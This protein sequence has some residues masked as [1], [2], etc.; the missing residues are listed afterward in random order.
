MNTDI[1]FR[2][3]SITDAN[4]MSELNS[5]N[6]PQNYP[7]YYWIYQLLFSNNSFLAFKDNLLIGYVFSF[8]LST[9]QQQTMQTAT[10]CSLVVDPDYRKLGIASK[11]L[12]LTKNSYTIPIKLILHVNTTN[13]NAKKLYEKKN[14]KVSKLIPNYYSI[15][16]DA[17]QMFIF[18]NF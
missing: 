7:L 9:D 15:N 4:I 5:K 10:I 18:K 14:F 12:D 11:L 16:Q 1:T 17:Y 2:I 8:S 6:L 3:A 13:H